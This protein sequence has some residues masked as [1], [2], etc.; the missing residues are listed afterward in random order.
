M[1]EEELAA[2]RHPDS[3]DKSPMTATLSHPEGIGHLNFS[4]FTTDRWI[5]VKSHL[6]FDMIKSEGWEFYKN[7][8]TTL[9]KDLCRKVWNDLLERGYYEAA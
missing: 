5:V 1:N 7:V 9:P 2:L 3:T 6:P 4:W 8:P